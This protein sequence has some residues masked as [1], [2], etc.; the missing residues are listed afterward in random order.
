MKPHFTNR[1]QWDEAELLNPTQTE[2]K[3]NV[4][5]AQSS[6]GINRTHLRYSEKSKPILQRCWDTF[7]HSSSFIQ[8]RSN[9]LSVP[10]QLTVVNAGYQHTTLTLSL[11]HTYSH[12]QKWEIQCVEYEV[13]K[14][15]TVLKH[16][17]SAFCSNFDCVL[18]SHCD[19]ISPVVALSSPGYIF[20]NIK[21]VMF[22]PTVGSGG[23]NS[24]YQDF[25]PRAV[26]GLDHWT[27]TS[28]ESCTPVLVTRPRS[29]CAWTPKMIEK[30][31]NTHSVQLSLGVP[32]HNPT[33]VM[34]WPSPAH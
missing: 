31:T 5:L 8:F 6:P 13:L 27:L 17:S 3:P 15:A 10:P 24:C 33:L 11:S 2:H 21:P 34:L 19:C 4:H 20:S 16:H 25:V 9:L 23:L 7:F 12:T 26:C 1:D 28:C 22:I 32:Q 18:H 14:N 30:K 29:T